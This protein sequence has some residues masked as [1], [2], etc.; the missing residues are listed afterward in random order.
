MTGYPVTVRTRVAWGDLDLFGHVN[1]VVYFRYFQAARIAYF[2]KIGL[3]QMHRTTGKGPILHSTDCRFLKELSYPDMVTIGATISSM[4]D[5]SFVMDYAV[6]SDQVGLV[7]TGSSVIVTLDFKTKQKI[8]IPEPIRQEIG[9]LE[10][11]IS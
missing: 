7:A 2:D 5:R 6:E 9:I 8:A 3:M 11:S 4:R 1:N 10:E